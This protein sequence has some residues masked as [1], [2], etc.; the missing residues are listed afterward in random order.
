MIPAA[1]MAAEWALEKPCR[2][3]MTHYIPCAHIQLAVQHGTLS[4]KKSQL[5]ALLFLQGTGNAD[6]MLQGKLMPDA[7]ISCAFRLL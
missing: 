6:R 5:D 4:L 7:C 1:A 3:M 2:V